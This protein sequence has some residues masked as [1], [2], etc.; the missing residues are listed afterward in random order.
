[1]ESDRRKK[2]IVTGLIVLFALVLPVALGVVG[3]WHMWRERQARQASQ[4]EFND[5]LRQSL[6]RAADVVLPAPSLGEGALTV[7][8]PA[9]KFESELQRVVRLAEGV[10]GAASSWNDGASVRV[11][12]SV[13]GSAETLFREAVERGVY[14][15]NAAG[16]AGERTVVEVLIRPVQPTPKTKQRKKAK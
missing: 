10:G 14:D 7:E 5:A 2:L 1:M 16:E 4:E 3:G 13:P 15:L 9:E 6:E 11:V 12:A 8:C